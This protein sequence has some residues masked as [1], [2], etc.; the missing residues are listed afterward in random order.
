[1]RQIQVLSTKLRTTAHLAQTM[2]L[3]SLTIDE[4]KQEIDSELA[5]NP[6]LEIIEDRRCPTCHRL[7]GAKEKCPICS[8]PNDLS[9]NEPV[10]FLSP[11]DDFYFTKDTSQEDD[12][13]QDSYQPS[14]EKLA[15]YV[16]RQIAPDIENEDRRIAAYIL[17]NLDEDGLLQVPV[18]EIARYLHVP[19]SRVTKIQ[20]IIQRADPLG[21]GAS[22]PQEALLTQLQF[23][24]ETRYIQPIIFD[25]I[26][27]K[28]DL[29]SRK[30]FNEIAREYHISNRRVQEIVRFIG[31]NLNPYPARSYWGDGRNTNANLEVY[32]QP[33]IMISYLN[34][35]LNNPL[36]VEIIMPLSGTLRVNPLIKKY[37]QIV[38]DEEKKEMWKKD[39]DSASLLV[40]C[41]QQRNHTMVRL[42]QTL[43]KLQKEF[44]INGDQHLKPITRAKIAQLLDVHESTI[45]RAVS[46]KTVQLPNKKIIPLSSFFDRNLNIRAVIRDIITN[47]PAPLSDTEIAEMLEE[48]GYIVARRTVAK[49]RAM[50]G[51]LPAHLRKPSILDLPITLS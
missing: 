37:C 7:L 42:M 19:I 31:D 33:D 49:Y 2:T 25:I 47:E 28:F 13:T 15:V 8:L 4:L 26:R 39:I 18:I 14:E 16:M 43:V 50:E 1:M 32:H 27:E 44:I 36:I 23:L 9:S 41:L 17:T 51:I 5:T 3:L 40:K 11:R 6:A 48:K 46:N 29:L 45:S 24:S 20:Q 22:T 38:D 12:V 10:V 30:Q 21:V 35:D 34:D